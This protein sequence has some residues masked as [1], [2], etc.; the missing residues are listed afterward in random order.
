MNILGFIVTSNKIKENIGFVKIVNDYSLI[1]DF[2]KPILIIGINKAKKISSNFNILNKKISDNIFWT[3]NKNENRE[4]YEKDLQKFY[5]YVI[6]NSISKIK[7]YYVNILK[8]KFSQIKNLI[9]IINNNIN[10]YIYI[11]NTMMYIYYNK[12]ILGISLEICEWKNISK[13]KIFAYVSK[14]PCNIISHEDF[15]INYKIRKF[16]Q[17]KEYLIAYFMS[18]EK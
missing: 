1:S 18:Y 6:F 4:E 9:N 7:Y 8:L 14:N 16:I 2:T 15:T 17:N 13:E 3:F 5:N 11:N 10:K 12:Y